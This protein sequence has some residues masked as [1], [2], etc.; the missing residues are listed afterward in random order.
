MLDTNHAGQGLER[1][2]FSIGMDSTIYREILADYFR[3]IMSIIS[4]LHPHDPSLASKLGN[5]LD[6]T[7][8]SIHLSVNMQQS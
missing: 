7:Q 3:N 2:F 5:P 6:S 1:V 4:H 8:T